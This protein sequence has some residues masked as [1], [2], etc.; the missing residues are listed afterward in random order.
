MLE[1]SMLKL[2]VNYQNVVPANILPE[3]R[4]YVL[5]LLNI[6]GAPGYLTTSLD[7]EE[8]VCS[9]MCL[10]FAFGKPPRQTKRG[11]GE[12]GIH[13]LHF[14]WGIYSLPKR[15]LTYGWYVCA[16]RC[17]GTLNTNPTLWHKLNSFQLLWQVIWAGWPQPGAHCKILMWSVAKEEG[18]RMEMA[19]R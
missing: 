9:G 13:L 18:K 3:H 4:R 16:A 8:Y 15:S 17:K 10:V 7:D 14:V 12:G 19:P 11:D 1:Y 5:I 6:I 2:C